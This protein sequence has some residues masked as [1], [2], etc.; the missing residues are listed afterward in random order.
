VAQYSP[1]CPRARRRF[2]RSRLCWRA[3]DKKPDEPRPGAKAEAK[4]ALGAPRLGRT[5]DVPALQP[6]GLVWNAKGT[7]VALSGAQSNDKL[8]Q[9]QPAFRLISP[10]EPTNGILGTGAPNEF[11]LAPTS[12]GKGYVTI[13]REDSLIS[14]RHRLAFWA[15]GTTKFGT[16]GYSVARTVSLDPARAFQYT[17]T[18]DEKAY[19]AVLALDGGLADAPRFEVIEAGTKDGEPQKS[20]LKLE[21][22]TVVLSAGGTR[23]AHL[24]ENGKTVTVYDVDSAKK[25][26]A[27]A[28]EQPKRS[29]PSRDWYV[30]L[31]PDGSRLLAWN[32]LGRA[33]VFDTT[34]GNAT[35]LLEGAKI[36]ELYKNRASFSGD[37]R[38]FA[39]LLE[40]YREYV[41]ELVVTDGK[42]VTETRYRSAEQQLAVW[43]TETGKLLKSWKTNGGLYVAFSPTRPVL[44]VAEQNGENAVRVG[45]W[46]FAAEVKK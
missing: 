15:Y 9:W 33:H 17:L 11:L 4:P 43:S 39:C 36:V 30:L 38:L 44:A 29:A 46:D 40:T 45:F 25:L 5:I 23:A 24:S 12:D 31:S 18:E 3:D 21:A 7:H 28:L 10:D 1:R 2:R 32:G 13:L 26:S 6:L 8:K 22:G 34:T 27:C 42:K 20:L 37:G 16:T 14:G 41:Q 19:R 35:P